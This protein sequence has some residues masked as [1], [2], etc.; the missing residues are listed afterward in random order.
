MSPTSAGFLQAGLLVAAL[1]VAYKPLGDYMARVFTS[2]RHSRVERAIYRVVK[3]SPET[4]QHWKIYA[5]GVLGFSFV[6]IILLYLLQ[7]LQAILPFNF[8]RGAVEEGIAFNTAVSFVTNTNW[9][10]YVPE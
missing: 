5:S 2:T 7:R 10:S 4:E 1:A 9:Q 8:G 3:V 6:S